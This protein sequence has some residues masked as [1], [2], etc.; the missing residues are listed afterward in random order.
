MV[1]VVIASAQNGKVIIS[2]IRVV[3]INVMQLET[4]PEVLAH[5]AHVAIFSQQALTL[6]L[7]GVL[8]RILL[9]LG[10]LRLWPKGLVHLVQATSNPAAICLLISCGK[11]DPLIDRG[12]G[13]PTV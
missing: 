6:G 10:E 3:S 4:Y 1:G 13:F 7:S 11:R 2:G 12:K 9:D 5:A 8:P